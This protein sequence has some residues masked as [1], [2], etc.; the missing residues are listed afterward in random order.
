MILLHGY[1]FIERYTHINYIEFIFF[2]ETLWSVRE[3]SLY[4]EVTMKYK[5]IIF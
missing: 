4:A 3:R 5:T 2:C 1:A